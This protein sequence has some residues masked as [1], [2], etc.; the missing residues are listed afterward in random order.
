M[1]ESCGISFAMGWWPVFGILL[2]VLFWGGIIALVVWVIS[3]LTRNNN[4]SHDTVALDTVRKRYARGEITREE[5][6]Q[7]KKDL[8]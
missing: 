1:S 8:Y 6:D 4:V 5:F 7:I 3:R 2:M